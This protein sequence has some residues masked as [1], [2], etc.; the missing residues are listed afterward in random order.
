MQPS[1]GTWWRK[2]PNLPPRPSPQSAGA[3]LTFVPAS[4]LPRVGTLPRP[5]LNIGE[6]RCIVR[7]MG[8]EGGAG[9]AGK[10]GERTLR[11]AGSKGRGT[12]SE[13]SEGVRR[14]GRNENGR[15]SDRNVTRNSNRREG[16][17]TRCGLQRGNRQARPCRR[18]GRGPSPAAETASKVS[19]V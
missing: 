19:R 7:K 14:D 16:R 5:V 15:A 13:Y 17:R 4:S 6:S 11:G 9:A 2:A 3:G 1:A 10:E 18:P 12:R 8:G